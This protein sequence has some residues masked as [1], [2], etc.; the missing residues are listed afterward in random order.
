MRIA[1]ARAGGRVS[2]RRA[3]DARDAGERR[4]QVALDVDGERLERRDVDDAAALAPCA[5]PAR[6]SGGRSRRG[7]RRASCPSRWARRRGR[8]RPSRSP[9]QPSRCARVGAANVSA[10]HSRT[11]GANGGSRR[12]G[13]SPAHHRG[14]GC[15]GPRYRSNNTLGMRRP[16]GPTIAA[17]VCA[18]LV[19]L[20]YVSPVLKDVVRTGLD[21]P[22]WIDHPEGLMNTTPGQVVGAAASPLPRRRVSGEFPIYYQSLSD[23]I[24]NVIAEPLGIPAMT[25]Q[26]V[27]FGPLLGFSFLLL[28]YLSIAA[29]VSRPAR[30]ARRQPPDLPR[31]QLLVPR[32]P[33]PGLRPAAQQRPPRAVPR[34]LARDGPEPRLG[35]PRSPA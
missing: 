4:A 2:P 27:L 23:S 14:A 19:G 22:I 9:A 3:G 16:S 17:F 7:R 35:A 10:N 30:G 20:L 29:V 28:N 11:A 18:V 13:R 5:G 34:D 15:D 8:S 21:W 25:V 24:L 1:D 31:R 12:P 6:T 32:P 26:A 33:R